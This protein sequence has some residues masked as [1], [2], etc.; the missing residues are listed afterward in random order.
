FGCGSSREGAVWALMRFGIRCVI[1]PGF[2][3]IFFSN[4]CQNGLLPV[5][6]DETQTQQLADAVTAAPEPFVRVDLGR[7]LVT[8]P[9]GEEI[10]FLLAEDRRTSLLEGLDETSL[11]LRHEAEIDEFQARLRA[12]QP[13]VFQAG[14]GR[15][16]G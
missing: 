16:A 15:K 12:D 14:T 7:C 9:D 5:V 11:I 3:E 2:G 8:W 13:W 6:L 1:A 10:P 4:A